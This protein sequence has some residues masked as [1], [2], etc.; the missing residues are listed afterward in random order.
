MYNCL[1]M[2]HTVGGVVAIGALLVRG[3]SVVIARKIFRRANSGTISST[4][5]ARCSNISA[6]CAAIWSMRRRIRG[7]ASTGCGS[8]AAT[9]CAPTSGRS[10]SRASP[11]RA[12]W[13]STRRPKAMSRST[14]SRAK[15]A[16]SAACRRFWRIA[17][18]W[19]WS[20]FD[21][22]RRRAG[23]RRGRPLHSAA[24]PTKPAK[25]SGGSAT[26]RREPGGAFEGYTSAADTE[27]KIL[28]NVF[29][30]G[31]AWYRTGDL[32]RMDAGGFFY[33]VDRIG[34]TF[35]WKGENVATS[36]V[37]AALTGIS[38]HR[39]GERLRR[40]RARHRRR[41]RH[42]GARRRPRGGFR[43]AAPASG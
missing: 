18:R 10:S 28:R 6:S 41:G 39:R 26:P 11:F 33:F 8:P 12:S 2:Y 9:A 29:E 21:A 36:E 13:N 24:R 27:R 25:R 38:R 17:F 1:P 35:R 15:S 40:C 20:S 4:G 3:G 42:G 23:A 19:R 37:A 16:P 32:M 7:S 31:D 43:R 5:T 34:D 22:E 30:A 14:T